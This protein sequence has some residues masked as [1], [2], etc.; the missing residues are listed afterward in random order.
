MAARDSW[1]CIMVSGGPGMI[2]EYVQMALKTAACDMRLE[3]RDVIIFA[4]AT[5]DGEI[6][7]DWRS[8]TVGASTGV[9]FKAKVSAD[10]VTYPVNFLLS[11]D[12][13]K[14]GA[15]V[16]KQ[17]FREKRFALEIGSQG[18]EDLPFLYEFHNL[19]VDRK[20]RSLN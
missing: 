7:T 10:S 15:A 2:P 6:T 12:D 11:E 1:V 20:G 8:Y 13:L 16:L 4:H 17:H 5:C 3:Q 9:L 18:A 19:S 14:R